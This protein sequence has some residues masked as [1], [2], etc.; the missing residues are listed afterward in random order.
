MISHCILSSPLNSERI[1]RNGKKR[2]NLGKRM[3]PNYSPSNSL[4]FK[5]AVPACAICYHPQS[6]LF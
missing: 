5:L 6:L 1:L 2:R 3:W 4:Q